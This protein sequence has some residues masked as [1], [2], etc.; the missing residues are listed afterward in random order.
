[1]PDSS[2]DHVRR[3]YEAWNAGGLE[4]LRPWLAETVELRD[5]PEMPDAGTVRGRDAVLARLREVSDAIGGGTVELGELVAIGEQVL[6]PM[7][8]RAGAAAG[9]AEFGEV[10]HLAQLEGEKIVSLH[11]FIDEGEAR[12]AAIGP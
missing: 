2:I 11:V 12:A 5:A 4:T 1:V 8:W 7:M 9:S 10:F 3:I 6:V